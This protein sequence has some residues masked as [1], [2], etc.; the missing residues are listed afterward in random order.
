MGILEQ[1]A[2]QLDRIEAKLAKCGPLDDRVPEMVDQRDSPLG[3]RRHC[4][5]VRKRR[6]DGDPSAAIVGRKH[7]LTRAALTEE[8][9]LVSLASNKRGGDTS[10]NQ[11]DAYTSALARLRKTS[12]KHNDG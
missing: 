9:H 7:L 1:M 3:R 5:I 10:P 12:R 4:A 2:L 11:G 6:A 8:L